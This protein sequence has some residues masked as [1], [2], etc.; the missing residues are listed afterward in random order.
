M[1]PPTICVYDVHLITF[2]YSLKHVET[3]SQQNVAEADGL[4]LDF[5][6]VEVSS[7]HCV[8]RSVSEEREMA[9]AGRES[10]IYTSLY[11]NGQHTGF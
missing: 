1:L 7:T 10:G 2:K 3:G 5:A 8:S 9:S 6:L 4:L 11:T